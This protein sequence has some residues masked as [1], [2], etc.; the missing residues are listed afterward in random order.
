VPDKHPA[1]FLLLAANPS[2]LNQ[3]FVD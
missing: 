2:V 3:K 1:V